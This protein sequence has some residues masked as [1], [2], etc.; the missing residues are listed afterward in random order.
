MNDC[1]LIEREERRAQRARLTL[2]V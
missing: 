1:G 2:A